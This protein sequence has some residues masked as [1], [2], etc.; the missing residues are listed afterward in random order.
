MVNIALPMPV[1]QAKESSGQK[2]GFSYSEYQSKLSRNIHP[3]SNKLVNS[4]SKYQN[5][6]ADYEI[7][8]P[9][10]IYEIKGEDKNT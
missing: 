4:I 10:S 9:T 3:N 2:G 6:L 8:L 5:C 1:E 7:K